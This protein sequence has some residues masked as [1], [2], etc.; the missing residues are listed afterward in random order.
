M[1]LVAL[2]KMGMPVLVL[3]MLV[4]LERINGK[5]NEIQNDVRDIRHNIT[6]RDTCDARHEE[7]NRRFGALGRN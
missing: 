3:G 6:W 4:L 2:V 5:V 1:E 7:I